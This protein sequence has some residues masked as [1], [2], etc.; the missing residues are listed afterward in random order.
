MFDDV[1]YGVMAMTFCVKKCAQ[2]DDIDFYNLF[3]K[4]CHVDKV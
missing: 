2:F 1:S 4:N 3:C